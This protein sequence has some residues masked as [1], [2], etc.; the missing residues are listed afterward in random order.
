MLSRLFL[1]TLVAF[2]VFKT[3]NFHS[4]VLQN[5]NKHSVLKEKSLLIVD[6]EVH[7]AANSIAHSSRRKLH[8]VDRSHNL[9]LKNVLTCHW[10][11]NHGPVQFHY[12]YQ[13]TLA[14]T[15]VPSTPGPISPKKCV[16]I[17]ESSSVMNVA[18]GHIFHE[19]IP[20]SRMDLKMY[21]WSVTLSYVCNQCTLQSFPFHATQDISNVSTENAYCDNVRTNV[22]LTVL[23]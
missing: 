15:R 12:Y 3:A 4:G 7:F 5:V 22:I 9:W 20:P 16:P 11:S 8:L 2:F 18:N 13:V 10:N 14:P 23:R 21:T 17:A 6:K 19:C 1:H